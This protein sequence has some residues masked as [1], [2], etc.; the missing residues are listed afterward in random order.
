MMQKQKG[1]AQRE[2]GGVYVVDLK[3][4]MQR[5]S[6]FFSWVGRMAYLIS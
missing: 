5:F 2:R 4:E 6:V 3:R 1:E